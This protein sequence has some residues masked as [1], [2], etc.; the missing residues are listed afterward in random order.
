M[1]GARL[2]AAEELVGESQA[3]GRAR[4]EE[5]MHDLRLDL[6]I[7]AGRSEHRA[8]DLVRHSRAAE[9]AGGRR[10]ELLVLAGESRNQRG[11]SLLGTDPAHHT[12]S[13]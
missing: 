1:R 7:V 4:V 5:L 12:R 8:L 9:C 11:A 6:R 10:R 13:I 3:L 2:F